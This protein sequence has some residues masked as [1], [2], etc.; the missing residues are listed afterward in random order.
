MYLT[1]PICLTKNGE[2]NVHTLVQTIASDV[3]SFDKEAFFCLIMAVVDEYKYGSGQWLLAVR[4]MEGH[5]TLGLW[6]KLHKRAAHNM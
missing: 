5:F 6:T 3:D 1:R 2:A 4:E